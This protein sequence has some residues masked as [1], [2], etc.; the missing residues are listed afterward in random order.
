MDPY[1]GEVLAMANLPNFDPNKFWK[2]NDADRRDRAVTDAYEPGST[3]KLVTAAAALESGKVN[4]RT[5]F[6]AKDAIEVGE[7]V[8][9][10]AEDG[11]PGNGATET[12]EEIIA[13]SHNVGAA[14][15]AM[16]ITTRK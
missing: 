6:A 13:L 7:H 8:I 3:F 16:A 15:V 1:T 14:E 12:L 10:N 5:R 2:Y 9:H 4:L 11:L